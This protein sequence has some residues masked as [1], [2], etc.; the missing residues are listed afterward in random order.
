[1]LMWIK[2]NWLQFEQR[3]HFLI[4]NRLFNKKSH[5]KGNSEKKK[6][7]SDRVTTSKN[8]LV[9]DH[10]ILSHLSHKR[11]EFNMERFDKIFEYFDTHFKDIKANYNIQKV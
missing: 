8:D 10:I 11:K 2:L 7:L 3:I 6:E 4:T 5:F 9:A 1:M